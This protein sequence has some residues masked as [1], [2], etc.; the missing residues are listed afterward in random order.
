MI[1]LPG[2]QLFFATIQDLQE[3]QVNFRSDDSYG[4]V[5]LPGNC[6]LLEAVS[7]KRAKEYLYDGEYEQRLKELE[8]DEIDEYW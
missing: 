7:P 6:G 2:T 3:F 1:I 4:F 5:A 8:Q